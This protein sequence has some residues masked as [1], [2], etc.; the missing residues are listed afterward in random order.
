MARSG[1]R[2]L[3][4]LL[5][6]RRWLASQ[7]NANAGQYLANEYSALS[8]ASSASL[9]HLLQ[10]VAGLSNRFSLLDR[11]A[12][13]EITCSTQVALAQSTAPLTES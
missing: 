9:D 6:Q 4:L 3:P 8:S 1:L 11:P 13:T 10:G 2:P 5:I 12:L 7:R